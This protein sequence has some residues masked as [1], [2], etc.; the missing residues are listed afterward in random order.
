[1]SH[2]AEELGGCLRSL[3]HRVY[4]VRARARARA[5]VRV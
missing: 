1:M 3:D 5:R 4:L 2:L